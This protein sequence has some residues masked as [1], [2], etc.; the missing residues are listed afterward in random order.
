MLA[1]NK[2]NSPAQIN[3]NLNSLIHFIFHKVIKIHKTSIQDQGTRESM[4][5]RET[6]PSDE[7]YISVVLISQD[8]INGRSGVESYLASLSFLPYISFNTTVI[9]YIKSALFTSGPENTTQC[10]GDKVDSTLFSKV[11]SVFKI[12]LIFRISS[13]WPPIELTPLFSSISLDLS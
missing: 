10:T 5:L 6:K 4:S 1:G 11:I 8:L 9:K 13:S 7:N 2:F 12:F 3:A